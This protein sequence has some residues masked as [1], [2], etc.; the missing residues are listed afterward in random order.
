MPLHVRVELPDRPGALGQVARAF[1]LAGADVL[2]VR[3]VDR[4]T[5]RAVDDF[6]LSWPHRRDRLLLAKAIAGVP[7]SVVLGMR[8]LPA[9]PDEN[10]L[11]DLV[12]HAA[13]NPERVLETLTDLAPAVAAADWAVI[14]LRGERARVL[15]A[16]AA[17]PRPVP[18]L[19]GDLPRPV[20]FVST[21]G[22]AISVPVPGTELVLVV[23]RTEEPPFLRR[24]VEELARVVALVLDVAQRCDADLAVQASPG[25][26]QQEAGSANL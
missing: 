6:V 24:E 25:R 19:P 3:V 5:G 16:S 4:V 26:L 22:P 9:V 1:A 7:G 21:S 17:A 14:V 8:L 15:Y 18:P 2:A 11:L 13:R 23:A 10:P 12:G 20:S